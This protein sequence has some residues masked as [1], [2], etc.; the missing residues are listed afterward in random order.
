[1]KNDI[2]TFVMKFKKNSSLNGDLDELC[3]FRKAKKRILNGTEH[4]II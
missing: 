4:C 2:G 3:F 1:M